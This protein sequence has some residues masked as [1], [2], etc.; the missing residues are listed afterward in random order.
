MAE[1]NG[2]PPLRRTQPVTNNP[3][4]RTLLS[5]IPVILSAVLLTAFLAMQF[6]PYAIGVTILSV[7]LDAM[8]VIFILVMPVL[9]VIVWKQLHDLPRR[10]YWGFFFLL[11]GWGIGAPLV[12]IMVFAVAYLRAW[13][14][15]MPA[16]AIAVVLAVVAVVFILVGLVIVFVRLMQDMVQLLKDGRR[17]HIDGTQ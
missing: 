4:V 12:A 17:A 13:E 16:I 3:L 15:P 5:W 10:G 6:L 14:P 11:T 8:V 1:D 7:L 2:D 9:E